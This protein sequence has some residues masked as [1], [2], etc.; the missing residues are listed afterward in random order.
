MITVIGISGSLRRGSFNSGLL[1]AAATMMPAGSTLAIETIA[2]IPLYNGD[3]EAASGLPPE[4]SRLKEAIA[5]A[6]GLFIATPEYNNGI[7]GVVK[8]AI[9][10][11]SRPVADIPRIFGGKPVGLAG[12]SPGGFGTVMAQAAWLP[13]LRLLGAELWPGRLLVSRAGGVFDAGGNLTDAKTG[14]L[15]AKHLAGFVAFAAS[16]KAGRS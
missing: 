2:G 12:A 1:R 8:N 14:E 11:L 16:R 13:V 10:W 5:A 9:D 7:P 6:D 15:L 4:V 3:D